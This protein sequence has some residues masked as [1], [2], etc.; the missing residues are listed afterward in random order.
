MSQETTTRPPALRMTGIAKSFGATAALSGVSFSVRPGSI[1]A[2]C[3][4][5]GAGKSTLMKVL[6]GVHKPDSGSIEIGGRA[7]RF[8]TPGEAL[9][10]GVSMIYQELDLAYD[11]SVA[12]NVFLG[13]EPSKLGGWLLD[14][15]AMTS[16]TAAL[17]SRYGFKID[18]SERVGALS[19]GDCQ[20]V[21][22]LKALRREAKIIVMDEPTSSLSEAEASRLLEIVR[23]LRSSGIAIVYISHRLE[24]VKALAD[25]IS[26][27]RDGRLVFSGSAAETGIAEIVRHM[28]GRDLKDFY[29]PRSSK[30]GLPLFQASGLSAEGGRPS[31]VSFEIRAGE[32]LGMAGLIGSGRTETADLIFGI[33]KRASGSMRLGGEELKVERPADAI[34]SGVAYLTED[35][36]R[37]GLCL[38]LPC[39]WNIT[40]ATLSKLGSALYLPPSNE[41]L[42]AREAAG[43]MNVKWA[44]PSAPASSL[45]GGN[46]QKLLLARWL[47]AEA[48]LL[49]F[50]EPTRGVDVG[51]KREIYSIVNRLAEEGR[52]ILFISSDLPELFGV[53][54]RLLVMRDGRVAGVLETS[55]S[56]PD[57]VMRLAAVS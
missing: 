22:M 17:A 32:V 27:L 16:R 31:D 33:S 50:D 49:I 13:S 28:V 30:P 10:A 43:S 12:E 5:N 34:R 18:P 23:Q 52:A 39:S 21:E 11:L 7:F 14:V 37:S 40:L 2:L 44:S 6:A 1:H 53:A 47:L 29:P 54:D 42:V 24:E 45:S 8:E 41:D 51:A 20:I 35:R 36:K 48:R 46:Q 56:S 19:T 26:V 38:E 57:E 3:G 15:D 4:E 25:D 9:D 55:K